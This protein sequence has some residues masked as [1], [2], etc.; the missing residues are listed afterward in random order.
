LR[1]EL[2]ATKIRVITVDPGQVLTVCGVQKLLSRL[3]NIH[4]S[5]EF[6]DIRFGYDK[7]KADKTYA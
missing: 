2:I 6:N 1:K 3:A 4:V 5:Q 7:E